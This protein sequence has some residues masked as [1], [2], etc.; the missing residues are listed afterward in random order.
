M[1]TMMDI[2]SRKGSQVHAVAPDTTV[3]HAVD[4]MN[5]ERIGDVLVQKS[6]RL[7]GIFAERD[8]LRRVVAEQRDPA[9]TAVS[10]VMT[11]DIVCGQPATSL[12][13]ARAVMRNHRVRHLPILSDQGELLGLVSLGDLNAWDLDGQE[14]TIRY[15][16]DYIYGRA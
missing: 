13:E 4:V 6:D 16:H 15:L 12:Q 2:L 5:R 7:T 10:E 1:A 14:M 9:K 3:L 8:L 11:S